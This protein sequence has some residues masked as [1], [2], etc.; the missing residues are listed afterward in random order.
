MVYADFEYYKYDYCG[1]M[2]EKDYMRLSR[3]ASAYLDNVC[4]DRIAK[5]T[6]EAMMAKIKDACC[7]VA[8]TYLLNE[9]GGGISA[10]TNDGI[11]VTYLNGTSKSLTNEQRLY[12]AAL[13]YLGNTGLMYRGVE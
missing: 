9:N 5:V 7:A 6:D 1:E 2:A 13:T 12:Q 4:F 3:Q 11:S 10:E 8:D